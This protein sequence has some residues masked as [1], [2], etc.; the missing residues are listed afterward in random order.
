MLK[1][2]QG[3]LVLIFFAL[4]LQAQQNLYRHF[5]VEEGLPSLSIHQV[6]Q[7]NLGYIW[8]ATD[9]GIGQYDGY[10]FKNFTVQDGLPTNEIRSIF[11][12]SKNRIWLLG[13][14]PFL[15]FIHHNKVH[16]VETE[17]DFE[18][19]NVYPKGIHEHGNII[20]IDT[21]EGLFS[22]VNDKFSKFDYSIEGL[23]FLVIKI[24]D[25]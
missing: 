10:R 4:N 16:R 6:T 22:Y 5:T 25:F 15:A 12:D 23:D 13:E 24:D 19:F 17:S 21:E 18:Q 9:K 7:D 11:I 3:L 2:L 8:L 14:L 1:H 20:Y